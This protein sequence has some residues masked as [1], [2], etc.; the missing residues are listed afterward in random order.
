[1]TM[2]MDRE[3]VLTVLQ[4][5]YAYQK[6]EECIR[7]PWHSTCQGSL[8]SEARDILHNNYFADCEDYKPAAVRD[9]DGTAY[10]EINNEYD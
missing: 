5:C 3:R 7:C 6:K 2:D 4:T 9:R 8:Y 10:V 1:M